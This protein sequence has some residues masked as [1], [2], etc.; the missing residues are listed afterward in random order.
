MTV[1]VSDNS[2]TLNLLTYVQ[3]H[4]LKGLRALGEG[5]L[6][7]M[8]KIVLKSIKMSW[9]PPWLGASHLPPP[10]C[11]WVFLTSPH[12][13]LEFTPAPLPGAFCWFAPTPP[14][15][16][17]QW[18]QWLSK[19]LS[20]VSTHSLPWHFWVLCTWTP[21][22]EFTRFHFSSVELCTKAPPKKSMKSVT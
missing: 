18:N 22:L 15:P 6:V 20:Q 9:F 14:P 2:W 13:V 1:T 7:W 10:W 4:F 17:G 16:F 3:E 12:L 11:L 19:I 5:G 21:H 8:T